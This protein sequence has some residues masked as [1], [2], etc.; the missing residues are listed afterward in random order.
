MKNDTLVALNF[1]YNGILKNPKGNVPVLFYWNGDNFLTDDAD[2]LKETLIHSD[3]IIN[4]VAEIC[5]KRDIWENGVI[6]Y[7]FFDYVN[8][9]EKYTENSIKFS[10]VLSIKEIKEDILWEE[11]VEPIFNNLYKQTWG[12]DYPFNTTKEDIVKIYNMLKDKYQDKVSKNTII[13]YV[14]E[15]MKTD[16]S[17]SDEEKSYIIYKL[18]DLLIDKE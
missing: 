6:Y 10:E 11:I 16:N 7:F 17:F 18:K 3:N 1:V 9:E 15:Q 8:G 13:N 12:T 4:Y 5:T 2:A 14:Y